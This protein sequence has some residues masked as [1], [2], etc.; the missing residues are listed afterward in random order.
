[1]DT[2]T[3][4]QKKKILQA[5]EDK[6]PDIKCPACSSIQKPDW[7]K[8]NDWE[9][10]SN[11]NE[12]NIPYSEDSALTIPP[13]DDSPFILNCAY[14]PLELTKFI[15]QGDK[16]LGVSLNAAVPALSFACRHCGYIMLFSSRILCGMPEMK[17]NLGEQNA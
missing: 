4:R 7:A 11:D 2:F 5:F 14:I 9:S 15:V 8:N 6:C 16:C 10:W 12:D 1:M 17:E 13:E 3:K